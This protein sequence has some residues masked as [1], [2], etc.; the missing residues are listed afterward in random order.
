M[1]T[2]DIFLP[3]LEKTYDFNLDENTAT[4]LI[5]EEVAV[6]ICQKEHYPD[7]K[8]SGQLLLCCIDSEKN[9]RPDLT[10]K[11]NGITS[12]SRLMLL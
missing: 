6:M 10:L 3:A 4:S 12:G 2:V 1:I 5:I 11:E 8:D 7:L 9:V